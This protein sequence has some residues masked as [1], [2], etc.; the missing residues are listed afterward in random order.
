MTRGGDGGED[1]GEEHRAEELGELFAERFCG[2]LLVCAI[3]PVG[4]RAA[5]ALGFFVACEAGCGWLLPV[6]G[7]LIDGWR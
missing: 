7:K 6:G 1:R 4:A 3:A 2:K 5:T